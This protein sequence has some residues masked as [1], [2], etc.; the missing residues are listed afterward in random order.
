MG[1]VISTNE[2]ELAWN[3]LRYGAKAIESGHSAKAFLLGRGV[4]CE[5]I[6]DGKFDVRRMMNDFVEKGGVVLACGTCLKIRKKGGT[7]LCP[8]S[9]MQDLVDLTADSDRILT[10]G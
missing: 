8:L 9:S 2:P 5:E 7:E 6:D 4:E 3:A 1:I 10:F